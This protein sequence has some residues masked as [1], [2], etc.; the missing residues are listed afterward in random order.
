MIPV[1]MS[2]RIYTKKREEPG[3]T[4]KALKFWTIN[5]VLFFSDLF[6]SMILDWILQNETYI[7][8]L[9]LLAKSGIFVMLFL[10][11]FHYSGAIYDWIVPNVL[12]PLQPFIDIVIVHAQ[13]GIGYL[14]TNV[15]PALAQ[16]VAGQM[17]NLVFILGGKMVS[18]L[19]FKAAV[20][21]PAT[22]PR[23]VNQPQPNRMAVSF[24]AEE[25]EDLFGEKKPVDPNVTQMVIPREHIPSPHEVLKSPEKIALKEGTTI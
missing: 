1:Y 5:A 7:S 16:S 17:K 3:A 13:M 19:E 6:E 2:H 25:G 23:V 4:E 20:T 12:P 22:A 21:E 8:C 24:I 9:Y 14:M 11:N 18:M 10:N 15:T